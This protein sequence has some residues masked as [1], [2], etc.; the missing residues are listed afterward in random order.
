MDLLLY[1]PVFYNGFFCLE[2]FTALYV[3]SALLYA[4]VSCSTGVATSTLYYP[5]LMTIMDFGKLNVYIASNHWIDEEYYQCISA[6]FS[7][8][9]FAWNS[10]IT[11]F[12]GFYFICGGLYEVLVML[13]HNAVGLSDD[14][15]AKANVVTVNSNPINGILKESDADGVEVDRFSHKMKPLNSLENI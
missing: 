15:S 1:Y 2:L 12:Y 6:L 4:P 9:I 5:I 14:T 13:L 10:F 11:T 8:H 7:I 3:W